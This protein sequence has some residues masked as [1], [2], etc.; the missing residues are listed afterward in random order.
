MRVVTLSRNDL[1]TRQVRFDPGFYVGREYVRTAENSD[2]SR[3]VQLG[4]IV[5][6]VHEGARLPTVSEGIPMLRLNSVRPCELD[7]GSA[8]QVDGTA[9]KWMNVAAGDVLFTRAAQP[10]RAAAV[11]DGVPRELA[12][13]SELT[14]IRPRPAVVPEYL[15]A[16]LCTPTLNGLLRDLAYQGR[17]SALPRLRLADIERLPIPL[18]PRSLQESVRNQYQRAL[19][20]TSQAHA[21]INAVV[22]AL[23]T[24]IDHRGPSATSSARTQEVRR[25]ALGSRWDV[26]FARGRA[27]RGALSTSTNMRPLRELASPVSPS[28]RGLNEDESVVAIQADEVNEAT[29]LVEGAE[30]RALSVL[31]SRMRQRLQ[32]GDVLLCTTGDG[33]QVAFLDDEVAAGDHP[34]LAS[35]TFTVLRF[36]ETPRVFAATLR[37]P[38]VRAQ[39]RLLSSGSVQRF[40]NKRDLDELLVPVLG[41]IWREDFETRLTRA[42]QRRREALLARAALIGAAD[43]YVREGTQ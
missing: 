1:G 16:V 31:S 6:S 29:F 18:P 23:Y 38:L 7:I 3:R 10:F 17:S 30:L 13:S 32:I 5:E 40:I 8:V 19:G 35:A 12:V 14:V 39:L 20:L 34:L 26:S 36:S 33:D 22:T 43:D 2:G 27:L 9:A 42:M 15:A 25:A 11:P 37:H 28:L 21:E 41:K 24:E 4:D